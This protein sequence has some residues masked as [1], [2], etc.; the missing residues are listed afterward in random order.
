MITDHDERRSRGRT[1]NDGKSLTDQSQADDTNIN[2]ILRKYGVTGVATGRAGQAQFLDHSL[3][4]TDLREAFE[5][6]RAAKGLRDTLP[7]AIRN[8]TIEELTTL[9]LEQ[10]NTILT[11]PAPPPAPPPGEEK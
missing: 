5:T 10:L 3:L 1:H 4:P 9:T 6:V 7:E 8:K 2:V 11:P